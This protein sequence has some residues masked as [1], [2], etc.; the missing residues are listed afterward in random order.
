MWNKKLGYKLFFLTL[1]L[2]LPLA[3]QTLA[4]EDLTVSTTLPTTEV[5]NNV[6]PQQNPDPSIVVEFVEEITT[7]EST[8]VSTEESVEVLIEG[9]VIE[10]EV[11]TSTINTNVDENPKTQDLSVLTAEDIKKDVEK[12][13]AEWIKSNNKYK[14]TNKSE[15]G[16]D[17]EVHEYQNSDGGVGY[18]IIYYDELGRAVESKGYGVEAESRTWVRDYPALTSTSTL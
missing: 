11:S 13:Q 12:E 10:T 3:F 16:G 8:E 6:E 14:Q 18:Q 5:D 2:I 15:T 4:F 9:E 7:D 17:Y 1:I